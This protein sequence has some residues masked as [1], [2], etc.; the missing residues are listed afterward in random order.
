MQKLKICCSA[1]Y[2]LAL[3]EKA[4]NGI[5]RQ[6]FELCTQFIFDTQYSSKNRSFGIVL[7]GMEEHGCLDKTL[8]WQPAYYG[9]ILALKFF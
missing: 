4:L 8:P 1:A 5:S 6:F 2:P 9:E 7:V 3:V